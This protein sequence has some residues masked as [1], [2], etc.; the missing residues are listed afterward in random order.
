VNE[1]VTAFFVSSAV[2]ALVPTVVILLAPNSWQR[3]LL[4][5]LIAMLGCAAL[6]LLINEVVTAYLT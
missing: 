3:A 4:G 1:T 5:Y 6:L 2:A